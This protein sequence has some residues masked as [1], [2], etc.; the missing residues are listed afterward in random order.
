M[1]NDPDP[2]A[3][4]SAAERLMVADGEPRIADGQRRSQHELIEDLVR[5][6]LADRM[7]LSQFTAAVPV[8]V[9]D[10]DAAGGVLSANPAACDLLHAD[11][12]ALTSKPFQTFVVGTDRRHVRSALSAVARGAG[13]QH[14]SV[15]LT[16]R[17]STPVHTDIAVVPVASPSAGEVVLAGQPF[18]RRVAARWVVEP[19]SG[20]DWRTDA[21]MLDAL[22]ELATL[23]VATTGLRPALSRVGELTERG[24]AAAKAVSIVAGPPDGP[25]I[26]VTTDTAAQDADGAQ[27]H[28]QQ[29]PSWDAYATATVVATDRF[30]A[31]PR[32]PRLRGTGLPA[33]AAAVP[34]LDAETVVGVLTVYGDCVLATAD[35]TGP[36]QLFARG[37]AAVIREHRAVADLR[38]LE[39][40]LREALDSR[41]L[42]GQ[43]T[44][45]LMGRLGCGPD[46]AFAALVRRSQR[47]N[48]KLR[49]IAA[50]LVEQTAQQRGG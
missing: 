19:Q 28:A 15:V 17:Q 38:T 24:L 50:R 29:G 30:G 33:A 20:S 39:R 44:G 4:G 32:W 41:A 27:H 11:R 6:R 45:V 31:D 5:S 25:D 3:D 43:A 22:A 12:R 14:L 36:T 10:T 49:V 21:S 1:D 42:I 47:E 48:I 7:S 18:G 13:T 40:Q 9:L 8:P 23:A 34:L 46:E 26:L 35:C 37:A 2:G 16:P